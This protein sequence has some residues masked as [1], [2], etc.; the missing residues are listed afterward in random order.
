VRGRGGSVK[1]SGLV[2]F[3]LA[4]P[5]PVA[6]DLPLRPLVV[7]SSPASFSDVTL[8]ALAPSLS[9][10]FRNGRGCSAGER[11]ADAEVDGALAMFL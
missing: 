6:H 10:I 5:F 2:A 11:L 1:V 3:S 4:F 7:L 8:L 9:F